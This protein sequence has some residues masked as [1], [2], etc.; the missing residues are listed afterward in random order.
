MS[1]I[2]GRN[3]VL[4][5]VLAASAGAQAAEGGSKVVLAN[6]KSWTLDTSAASLETTAMGTAG[7]YRTFIAGLKEWKLSADFL[8][9]QS[10]AAGGAPGADGDTFAAGE[11][12]WVYLYPDDDANGD[13]V[14]AG[15]AQ[16]ES[17]SVKSTFDGIVDCSASII[18]RGALT[19]DTV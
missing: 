15:S 6:L 18:A 10:N 7:N 2:S 1:A 11:T 19:K 5:L 13:I 4:K 8:Y 16:F 9:D 17:I 12:V 3:G 14:Y